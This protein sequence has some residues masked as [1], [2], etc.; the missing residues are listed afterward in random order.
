MKKY[1]RTLLS[2]I[3]HYSLNLLASSAL[4]FATL[5]INH[6]CLFVLY[7]YKIPQN[8]VNLGDSNDD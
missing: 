3:K 8:H 7:E 1:I 2:I 4:L 6:R 5:S